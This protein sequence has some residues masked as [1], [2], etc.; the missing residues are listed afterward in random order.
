MNA[1]LHLIVLDQHAASEKKARAE[2]G[3]SL[4]GA[5]ID[6]VDALIKLAERAVQ[7]MKEFQEMRKT[8]AAPDQG[9]TGTEGDLTKTATPS[10][11]EQDGREL[12]E[13]NDEAD[14]GDPDGL[15]P[16]PIP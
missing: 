14:G 13:E 6:Q 1:E 16:R 8:G 11:T 3:L 4:E 9:V 7:R 5:S 10:W 2:I 12:A 15:Q